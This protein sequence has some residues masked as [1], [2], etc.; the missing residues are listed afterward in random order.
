MKGEILS[1]KTKLAKILIAVIGIAF[2][3][4]EIFEGTMK[5]VKATKETPETEEIPANVEESENEES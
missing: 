4:S 5:L 2:G 1:M 3:A